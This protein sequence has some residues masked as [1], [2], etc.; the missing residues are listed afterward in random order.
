M[1]LLEIET[2]GADGLRYRLQGQSVSRGWQLMDAYSV[3]QVRDTVGAGDWC[4]AGLINV[5]GVH[6]AEGLRQAAEAEVEHAL[7]V[8]QAL[9][10][11]GC[12]YEGARGGM[13][14]LGKRQFRAAIGRIL[15]GGAAKSRVERDDV[16]LEE[17]WELVCP[18]CASERREQAD[19]G[20]KTTGSS[21]SV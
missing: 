21:V 16:R 9:G 5:I 4:T 12:A 13:Y 1:P 2:L 17:L 20:A 10:A 6:G 11:F 15:D 18:A 8:G 3:P 7:R 19:S 14:A